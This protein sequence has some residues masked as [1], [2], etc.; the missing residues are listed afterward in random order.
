MIMKGTSHA[1]FKKEG[2]KMEKTGTSISSETGKT[3]P[4]ISQ[5]T[6]FNVLRDIDTNTKLLRLEE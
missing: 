3:I 2:Y 1:I 6:M 5:L 4:S